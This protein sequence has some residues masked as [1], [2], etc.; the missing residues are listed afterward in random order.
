MKKRN[1]RN[2]KLKL[3]RNRDEWMD[4]AQRLEKIKE[5]HKKIKNLKWQEVNSLSNKIIKKEK[6]LDKL[7]KDSRMI[8]QKLQDGLET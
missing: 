4:G 2:L 6:Y 7:D 1:N 5:V 3:A 8:K